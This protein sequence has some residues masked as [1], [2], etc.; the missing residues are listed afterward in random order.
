M[1]GGVEVEQAQ[2]TPQTLFHFVAMFTANYFQQPRGKGLNAC[3]SKIKYVSHAMA[4]VVLCL[5][6]NHV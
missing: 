6:N 4:R 3:Y 5:L 1:E 2:Y